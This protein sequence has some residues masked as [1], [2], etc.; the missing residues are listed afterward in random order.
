MHTW[1][2]EERL[3]GEA[4]IFIWYVVGQVM[5]KHFKQGHCEK[6]KITSL[7]VVRKMITNCMLFYIARKYDYASIGKRSALQDQ[8]G[9]HSFARAIAVGH[10]PLLSGWIRKKPEVSI[11]E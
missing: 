8:V 7:L 5:A 4:T 1:P 3:K 11:G 10:T 9:T 2:Q 6:C